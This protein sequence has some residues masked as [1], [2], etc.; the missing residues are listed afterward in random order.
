[1]SLI[2]GFFKKDGV[3]Q[4]TPENI[5]LGAGTIYKN[6]KYET[7][8]GW[9]GTILA[10]T[11]GGNKY[12]ITNELQDL[13]V[14]GVHVKTKKLTVKQGETAKL[15]VSCVEITEEIAKQALLADSNFATFAGYKEINTRA[16]I[17]SDKDYLDNIAFVGFTTKNEPIIIILENAICT[18]GLEGDAK[19]K[20]KMVH[21]LTF[22]CSADLEA[23][24]H[25]TLPV[26]I[27]MVTTDEP[28]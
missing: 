25:G 11:S 23:E 8:T 5:M 3:T 17:N 24:D 19:D 12:S 18:S 14:D 26:K 16:D 20:D 28:S 21:T 2:K 27:Y 7:S 10:A 13:E 1:M 4:E 6:L 22:E 9:T 15:E